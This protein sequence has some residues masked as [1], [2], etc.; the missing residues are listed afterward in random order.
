MEQGLCF[1]CNKKFTPSHKC[2]VAQSFLIDVENPPKKDSEEAK[3][4]MPFDSTVAG[5]EVEIEDLPKVSLHALASSARPQA[6]RVIA[7]LKGK[8]VS[9]LIDNR[10]THNF[11]STKVADKL[12]I[13]TTN[14]EPFDVRVANK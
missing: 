5:S 9:L 12:Q 6:I 10:S 11:I 13:L 4:D 3:P 1:R 14:I 8:V 7:L 2:K